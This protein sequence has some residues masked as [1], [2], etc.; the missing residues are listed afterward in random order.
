MFITLRKHNQIVDRLNN[1]KALLE[2][3]IRQQREQLRTLHAWKE[4]ALSTLVGAGNI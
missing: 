2:R 4:K 3:R 1:K